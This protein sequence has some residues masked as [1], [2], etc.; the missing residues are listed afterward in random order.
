MGSPHYLQFTVF[1]TNNTSLAKDNFDKIVFGTEEI[2]ELKIPIRKTTDH[3]FFR[4]NP[5][6]F[7]ITVLITH[8]NV[9]NEFYQEPLN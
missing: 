9:S 5:V 8:D 6:R 2:K 7:L 3:S 1:L 4:W